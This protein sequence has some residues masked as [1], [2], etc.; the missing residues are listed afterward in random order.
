MFW[1]VQILYFSFLNFF[2]SWSQ[3]PWTNQWSF[4]YMSRFFDKFSLF[5]GPD[6]RGRP[7][8]CPNHL[9]CFLIWFWDIIGS[10]P[11]LYFVIF[12]DFRLSGCPFEMDRIITT[13]FG[14]VEQWNRFPH[15]SKYVSHTQLIPKNTSGYIFGCHMLSYHQITTHFCLPDHRFCWI[16]IVFRFKNVWINCGRPLAY[17]NHSA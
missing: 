14:P 7:L 2:W 12:L 10:D 15:R 3:I 9:V 16:C 5:L 4:E 6:N 13:R 17:L 11:C 8:A 1:K